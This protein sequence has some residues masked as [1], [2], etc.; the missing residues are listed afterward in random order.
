MYLQE[1]DLATGTLSTVQSNSRNF[2][3]KIN[4]IYAMQVSDEQLHS[5]SSSLD[6]STLK[7]PLIIHFIQIM[8]LFR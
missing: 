1:I 3:S 4:P 2:M 6:G 7:V 8:L 5:V